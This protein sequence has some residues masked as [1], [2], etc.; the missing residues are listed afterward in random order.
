MIL[1]LLQCILP[2]LVASC[3]FVLSLVFHTAT[4]IGFEFPSYTYSEADDFI[5]E[6]N[7]DVVPIFLRK[8]RNSEQ[9]FEIVVRASTGGFWFCGRVGNAEHGKDYSIGLFDFQ[10]FDFGPSQRSI[11]L[12]MQILQDD[13]PEGREAARLVSLQVEGSFADFNPSPNANIS[14]RIDDDGDCK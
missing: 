9:T 4:E 12:L 5:N 6:Y 2:E 8:S 14:I 13:I 10:I 7:P 11:P 3:T 1:G